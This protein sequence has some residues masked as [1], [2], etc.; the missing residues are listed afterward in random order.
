LT[1]L[2]KQHALPA[3]IVEYRQYAK[4]K[5]TYVDGVDPT[6]PSAD[7]ARSHLVQA[8]RGGDRPAEFAGA[9]PAEHPGSHAEGREIRSAFVPGE[10]G[11]KL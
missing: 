5:S 9:E 1:E 6:D 4:L 2:A 3:K 10:D 11:W 7:R 8:G